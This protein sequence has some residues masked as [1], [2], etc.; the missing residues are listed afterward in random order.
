MT[1][2]HWL[3]QIGPRREAWS[4]SKSWGREAWTFAVDDI[5]IK[6]TQMGLI[7]IKYTASNQTMADHDIV[8]PTQAAAVKAVR[9]LEQLHKDLW[10]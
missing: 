8:V 6:I 10:S 2:P 3:L 4:H 7:N 5:Q 9:A 1:V